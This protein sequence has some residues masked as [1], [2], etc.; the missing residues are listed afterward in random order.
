MCA[1]LPEYGLA[2]PGCVVGAHSRSPT[3]DHSETTGRSRASGMMTSSPTAGAVSAA[4][5]EGSRMV[6][7]GLG[8][9]VAGGRGAKAG[10][11]VLLKE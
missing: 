1:A 3:D 11:P 5:D 10:L 8:K 6:T 7:E 4:A 9:G 2:H